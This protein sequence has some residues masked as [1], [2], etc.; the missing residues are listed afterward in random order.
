MVIDNGCNNNYTLNQKYRI[1]WMQ[2]HLLSLV[3]DEQKRPHK[4]GEGATFGGIA[5]SSKVYFYFQ[6]GSLLYA[7]GK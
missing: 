1:V 7:A 4:R 2:L 6:L 5:V 3:V